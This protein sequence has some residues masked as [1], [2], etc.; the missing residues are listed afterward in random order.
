[1]RNLP[2]SEAELNNVQKKKK[3]PIYKSHTCVQ[4]VQG[5]GEPREENTAC[6]FG[7][8]S[9]LSQKCGGWAGKT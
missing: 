6:Q 8:N 9:P 4:I 7:V 1:M 5:S 3:K 2:R